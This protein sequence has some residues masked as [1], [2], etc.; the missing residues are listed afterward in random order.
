MSSQR[1][2]QQA[3]ISIDNLDDNPQKEKEQ[4]DQDVEVEELEEVEADELAT[5]RER[6]EASFRFN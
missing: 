6:R 1:K 5:F 2:Y 4:G 3:R